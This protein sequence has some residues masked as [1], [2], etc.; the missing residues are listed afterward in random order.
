MDAARSCQ[1]VDDRRPPAPRARQSVHDDHVGAVSGDSVPERPAVEVDPPRLHAA[2]LA[3]RGRSAD[4]C[5][6]GEG[7]GRYD[8]R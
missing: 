5:A 6:E 2:S 4:P 8:D 7:N 1:L 3:R